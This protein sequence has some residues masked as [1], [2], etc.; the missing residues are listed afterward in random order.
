MFK[1]L[2]TII[3][4]IMPILF[5][6][7][8]QQAQSDKETAETSPQKPNV[9]IILVDDMGYS[10]IG[11]FGS[12]IATPTL[13]ALAEGGMRMTN[14]YNAA[15]CCPSR[16]AL[17]TGLYP[18]QAGIGMMTR[19]WGHPSYRGFLTKNSV[20]IAEVLKGA[21]Y[22]T[23]QVGKW[24]VGGDPAHWPNRRGFDQHFTFV[25]GASSYYNLWPY[26]KGQDTLQMCYNGERFYPGEGFYSTDAFSDSASAFIARHDKSQPFFMYLAYTAPHW[27]LH[28]LPE[29]IAKYR[30]KYQM[31][32]DSLRRQ[33]YAKMKELGILDDDV[34]LSDRYPTITAW[35]EVSETEKDAW[36]EKM[37]L[38]AA[39]VD[40]M[41]QG[42][43]QIV[44]T[45]KDRDMFDNTL[46]VFL[47]DNGA[48][49]E[50]MPPWE[51]PY[52]TD[53]APGSE[54]SFPSYD[55]PWANAS[56]TPYRYFKS[57]LLQG[58][59]ATPFVASFP[60]GGIPAGSINSS[61]VGHI[62]DL[63]ATVLDLAG[64]AYPT[65]YKGNAV[66]PTPGMSLVPALKGEAQQGRQT[67]FWEHNR[68]RAVRDGDW[69]LVSTYFPLGNDAP[70]HEWELYNL[71][72]DPSELNDLAAEM[73][74]KVAEM[75]EQYEA[76]AQ[77][78]G[79]LSLEQRDS[80][81]NARS[82]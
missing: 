67:L 29:D 12:E 13:D 15:R 60:N 10:D 14:F 66:T 76:W 22:A 30:G 74:E 77:E 8:G 72:A 51:S 73:P 25:N 45:L 69:K 6:C 61:T 20:T 21:G 19:D 3:F 56:N 81:F 1:K 70:K 50:R 47:S 26:R 27:P 41:D 55:P 65:E 28:A 57:Y 4:L 39:V 42:V 2:H 63:M 11:C 7:G 68:N 54:R 17:L 53:G 80:L 82:Q 5:G 9:L 38:Y 43:G 58:G 23:Y 79:A 37:A 62:T 71:A 46:I 48:C 49:H 34:P 35:S 31:G 59:M 24:H 33:R 16:A 75:V 40:R 64:A 32:W 44:N 18:H 36:D 52:P 78:V